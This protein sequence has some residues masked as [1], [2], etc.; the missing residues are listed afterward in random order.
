MTSFNKYFIHINL[1]IKFHTMEYNY[2]SIILHNIYNV[3]NRL[4]WISNSHRTIYYKKNIRELITDYPLFDLK[5]IRFS[6]LITFYFKKCQLIVSLF[7]TLKF[8]IKRLKIL[9]YIFLF[10]FSLILYDKKK[11]KKCSYYKLTTLFLYWAIYYTSI[12]LICK[13]MNIFITEKKFSR[14]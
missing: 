4:T 1:K 6:F 7:H 8:Y 2:L 12:N 10:S 3:I 9:F 11:T 14:K 13:R 5:N